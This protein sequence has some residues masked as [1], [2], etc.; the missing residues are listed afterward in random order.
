MPNNLHKIPANFNFGVSGHPFKVFVKKQ[1]SIYKCSIDKLS[2]VYSFFDEKEVKI[3]GIDKQFTVKNDDHL[4][5]TINCTNKGL[6]ITSAS[7]SIK[8]G[9]FRSEPQE[10]DCFPGDGYYIGGPSSMPKCL[11][12]RDI[13]IANFREE[14]VNNEK[15]LKVNQLIR[16]HITKYGPGTG[17]NQL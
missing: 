2:M 6:T 4:I 10:E 13:E 15:I 14:T 17:Y 3:D 12:S 16:K 8:S 7:L 9:D 5:L 1:G 11:K